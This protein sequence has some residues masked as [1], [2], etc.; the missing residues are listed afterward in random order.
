MVTESNKDNDDKIKRV[1]QRFDEYKDH[2]EGTHVRK[3]ICDLLHLQ[4]SEDIKEIKAD[5]KFIL[6]EIRNGKKGA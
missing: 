3:E 6:Q 5:V 1:Y 2:L 4:T